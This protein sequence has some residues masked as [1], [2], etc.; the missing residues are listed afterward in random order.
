MKSDSKAKILVSDISFTRVPTVLIF[1]LAVKYEIQ[2]QPRQF[3]FRIGNVNT[4][5]DKRLLLNEHMITS[6]GSKSIE[7]SEFHFFFY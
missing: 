1:F 5:I 7:S 4:L 2:A 6:V 3:K